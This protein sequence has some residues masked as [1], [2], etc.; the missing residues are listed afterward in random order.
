MV[1]INKLLGNEEEKDNVQGED[2]EEDQFDNIEIED[3]AREKK[4]KNNFL[5]NKKLIIITAVVLIIFT[6]A[7]FIKQT[8]FK[9]SPHIIRPNRLIFK[10]KTLNPKPVNF[11]NKRGTF[12]IPVKKERKKA[13]KEPVKQSDHKRIQ[14]ISKKVMK[15][16][17]YVPPVPIENMKSMLK[18]NTEIN[19]LKEQ[20]QIAQLRQQIKTLTNSPVAGA[21]AVNSGNMNL[22]LVG[23]SKNQAI[24]EFGKT[25][26]TMSVGSSYDGYTCLMIKNTGIVLEKGAKA[27]NLNFSM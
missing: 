12:N 23:I 7:V 15:P 5:K 14:K 18:F 10:S 26:V 9:S 6:A 20:A 24:V 27:I 13:G 2:M 3:S 21:G 19:K 4:Q 17:V 1:L 8:L 25:D 22:S 11:L 16:T